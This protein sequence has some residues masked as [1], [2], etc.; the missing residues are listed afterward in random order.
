MQKIIT[1]LTFNDQAEEAANYYV[2]LFKNASIDEVTR[3]EEG[4]PVL[5]VEFTIEGQPF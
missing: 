5:I 4:G 1:F 2:S 3:Q